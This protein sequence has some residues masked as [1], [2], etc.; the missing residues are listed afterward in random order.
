[1]TSIRESMRRLFTPIK[2]LPAG[3][4]HRQALSGAAYPYRLH[5]RLDPDGNGALI[6]NASTILHL[7]QTAAEYAY[8]LIAGTSPER[9]A[10][11]IS[12][13][14]RI[15][16]RRASQDFQDLS[17]RILT[18]ANTTDL[19]PEMFLDFNRSSPDIAAPSIPYRLD[20]ALTY[21][22]PEGTNPYFAP[23]KR[24]AR[25]LTTQEWIQI[26][27]K[28]WSAGVPHIIFTG[29]EPYLRD[30]L[31]ELLNHAEENGQ[32]TGLL[33]D[34]RIFVDASRL[35]A[36]L[37]TGLDYMLILLDPA[38]EQTWEALANLIAADIFIAVHL[39]LTLQNALEAKDVLV[40][41]S[42]I[43]VTHLSLSSADSSLNNT[44]ADL[45]NQAAS[46]SMSLVWDL[47]VP[48]SAHNPVALEVQEDASAE[49]LHRS[50]Y[51]VEPDGD[52]C[53]AQ[54]SDLVLGNLLSDPV[55]SI[56]Q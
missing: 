37:N 46:L 3:L 42:E 16:R 14:Y 7:N 32:V 52:V 13:R 51:Y 48:F 33:T 45:R 36:I 9:V 18:L 5:L 23:L 8:H 10:Q 22:L 11:E 2:P 38:Q 53:Q 30:D 26:L 41:L 55:E 24:V 20:C 31:A 34:G 12:R 40:H 49:P 15:E 28:A 1:M 25:E 17:Q 56:W 6:V 4:Y 44:L 47:P 50:S 54:G 29:G 19:D 43:G 27:D 35:D 21:R 39:T